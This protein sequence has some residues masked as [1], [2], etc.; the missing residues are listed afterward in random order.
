MS[1]L[2]TA[3]FYDFSGVLMLPNTSTSVAIR[4]GLRHHPQAP[5]SHYSH[6]SHQQYTVEAYNSPNLCE[7]KS[8]SVMTPSAKVVRIVFRG[9]IIHNQKWGNTTHWTMDISIY[10]IRLESSCQFH[11]FTTKSPMCAKKTRWIFTCYARIHIRELLVKLARGGHIW[12]RWPTGR[13]RTAN[14]RKS[15]RIA[16]AWFVSILGRDDGECDGGNRKQDADTEER[17]GWMHTVRIFEGTAAEEVKKKPKSKQKVKN[18]KRR[19]CWCLWT[20]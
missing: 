19:G 2:K 15:G 8:I 17:E 3:L 16:A 12:E 7:W 20:E 5:M 11:P 1:Q 13:A 4:F 18:R 6:L 10:R 14:F 9:N